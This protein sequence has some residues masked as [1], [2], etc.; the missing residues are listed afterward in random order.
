MFYKRSTRQE[1]RHGTKMMSLV[2]VNAVDR[3]PLIVSL[4]MTRYIG[5]KYS[6][7]EAD[8]YMIIGFS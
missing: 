3:K 1:N 4:R 7:I 6:S 5:G 2:P 8:S